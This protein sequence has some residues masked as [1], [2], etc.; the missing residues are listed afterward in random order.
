MNMNHLTTLPQ[1]TGQEKEGRR[2]EGSREAKR[3]GE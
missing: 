2:E 3:E 1:G